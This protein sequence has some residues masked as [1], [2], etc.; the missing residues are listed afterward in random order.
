MA[1]RIAFL[2]YNR[3]RVRFL[4][5]DSGRFCWTRLAVLAIVCSASV[6]VSHVRLRSQAAAAPSF[7]RLVEQLSEPG[8]EFD[9]DNLISNERSYLHVVPAIEQSGATGGPARIFENTRG[10]PGGQSDRGQ[11]IGG[12]PAVVGPGLAPVEDTG[13]TRGRYF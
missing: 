10:S 5:A 12:L 6:T 9:T 13:Q 1:R 8:G 3:A 11:E 2:T 4:R 7:A